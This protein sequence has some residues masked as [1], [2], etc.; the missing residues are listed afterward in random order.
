MRE[1]PKS[2]HLLTWASKQWLLILEQCSNCSPETLK[3]HYRRFCKI[4]YHS[5]LVRSRFCWFT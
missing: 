2:E 5:N 3:H 1:G 4:K